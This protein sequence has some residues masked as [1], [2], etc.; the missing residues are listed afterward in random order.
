MNNEEVFTCDNCGAEVKESDTKCPK[1]GLVFV[2]TIEETEPEVVYTS[3]P[4]SPKRTYTKEDIEKDIPN[5]IQSLLRYAFIAKCVLFVL[6]ILIVIAGF[7]AAG[8]SEGLSIVIAVIIGFILAGCGILTEVFIKWKAYM[9]FTN[10][11][12][13][14]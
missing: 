4:S 6:A 3:S 1:C 8:D 10:N 2:E 9:L 7:A 13:Q 14:I 11:Q 5:V 12:N